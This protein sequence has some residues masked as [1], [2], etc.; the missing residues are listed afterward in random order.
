MF[1]RDVCSQVPRS[2]HKDKINH[3]APYKPLLQH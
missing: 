2:L 3:H 1:I